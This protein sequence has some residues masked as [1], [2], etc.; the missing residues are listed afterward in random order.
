ML[1]F[2]KNRYISIIGLIIFLLTI[3]GCKYTG[4][5]ESTV[6]SMT[7][8]TTTVMEDASISADQ[9]LFVDY[10]GRHYIQNLLLTDIDVK[11]VLNEKLGTA[12][13]TG[14]YTG[15]IEK[16]NVA[17]DFYSVK[18]CDD[19]A[20]ICLLG[21][22]WIEFYTCFDDMNITTCEA[23]FSALHFPE[24]WKDIYY[25]E[26]EDWNNCNHNYQKMDLS[27]EDKDKLYECIRQGIFV[28]TM[29]DGNTWLDRESSI[30]D[31][32]IYFQHSSGYMLELTITEDGYVWIYCMDKVV[33]L[34][35]SL[36]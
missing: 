36:R 31:K 29:G 30:K 21:N 18:G 17:G 14:N 6:I 1:K 24:E 26:Y 23:L 10:E 5:D 9:I 28:E 25:Q 35:K 27:K 11:Q 2:K 20:V 34:P 7:E 3:T 4:E 33:K 16:S 22:G 15:K 8:S 19:V 12:D 32:H 13:G